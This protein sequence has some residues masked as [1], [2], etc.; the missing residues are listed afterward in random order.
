MP[1]KPKP[2]RTAYILFRTAR[3]SEILVTDPTAT[4]VSIAKETLQIWKSMSSASQKPFVVTASKLMAD[5]NQNFKEWE[6]QVEKEKE[7]R[8]KERLKGEK[9]ETL[10]NIKVVD[11]A[12]VS[13][14]LLF[15]LYSQAS[16]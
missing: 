9:S 16:Q 1:P 15:P 8:E 13:S 5:Y 11:V 2:P 6:V 7:E 4:A 14:D 3:L 10:R 12:K